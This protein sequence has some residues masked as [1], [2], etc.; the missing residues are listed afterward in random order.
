MIEPLRAQGINVLIN[1]STAIERDGQR[2]W[3]VGTDDCHFFKSHDLPTAFAGLQPD[4]FVIFVS[5]S[6]EIY[7]EASAYKPK[8]YLCGHTHAG[9]IKIPPI[10]PIFT[11]SSA[12]R[13]MCEGN[14][15]YDGMRGYTSGGVG[16]SGVPVRFNSKGEVTVITLRK[17]SNLKSDF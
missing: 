1:D 9:Q 16:V 13:R 4:S 6:N 12:P 10:G 7:R 3:I 17:S 14:W 5:H 2:L 8:L 11:H 15:Q